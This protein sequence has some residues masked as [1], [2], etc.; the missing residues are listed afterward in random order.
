MKYRFL[1]CSFLFLVGLNTSAQNKYEQEFRISEEDFPAKALESIKSYVEDAKRIR[2]YREIDS[3]KTSFEAKFKKGKLHYS[4]EFNS[5]GELEDVEFIIKKTDVP[6]DAWVQI[7]QYLDTEFP[8]SKIKKIQQQYPANNA[9]TP[10]VLRE[11][12]QN[13]LLPYIRYELIFTSKSNHG[14][15]TYEGL[16]DAEG[17]LRNLRKSLTPNY[18]HLLY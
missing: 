15:Q 5:K 17:Q 16:F 7:Q 12:F 14:F 3:A 1:F 13:L 9:E 8:R 10:K 18:D 4:V 2:F 11:A 6:E